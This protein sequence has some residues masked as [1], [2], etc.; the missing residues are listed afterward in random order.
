MVCFRNV[1]AFFMG[2]PLH[3]V[4]ETYFPLAALWPQCARKNVDYQSLRRQAGTIKSL[5]H[6]SSCAIALP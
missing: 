1:P 3:I 4:V 6:P 5:I 2:N